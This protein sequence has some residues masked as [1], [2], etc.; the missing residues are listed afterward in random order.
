MNFASGFLVSLSCLIFHFAY[1]NSG[2][3]AGIVFIILQ[4]IISEV[5]EILCLLLLRTHLLFIFW[6]ETLF[7]KVF[8]FKL[9]IFYV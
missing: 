2:I 1:V 3:L 8:F 7:K 6:Y 9:T 5:G 4:Q